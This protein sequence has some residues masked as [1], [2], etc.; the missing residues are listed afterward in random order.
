[1]GSM[2]VRCRLAARGG[3]LKLLSLSFHTEPVGD[4]DEFASG[5]PGDQITRGSGPLSYFASVILHRRALVIKSYVTAIVNGLSCDRRVASRHEKLSAYHLS[6]LLGERWLFPWLQLAR[7]CE[8]LPT[9]EHH[10]TG[11]GHCVHGACASVILHRR[12][13]TV[14]KSLQLGPCNGL[15]FFKRVDLSHCLCFA[16]FLLLNL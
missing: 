12:V 6:G 5:H 4:L 1:M 2:V 15:S 3:G 13:L 10:D 9:A 14:I 7:V 8:V 11:R 16:Y